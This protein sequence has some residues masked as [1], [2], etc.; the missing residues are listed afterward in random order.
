MSLTPSTMMELGTRAPD[1]ELLDVVTGRLVTRSEFEGCKG[2]LVLFICAHC[3]YVKH[4]NAELAR[5]GADYQPKD[6]GVVAICSNDAINYPDDAPAK[7]NEQAQSFGFD[8][9]Y[10]HDDSQETAKAYR[11]A[12]TPDIFLFDED[13]ELVYRGQLDDSRPGS[14]RPVTGADLRAAIDALLAGEPVDTEQLPATGCN[15][16]W[17]PGSEPDYFG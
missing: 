15:I 1:F 12:C 14:G 11:A 7:L 5:L 2:L 17:K 10:L 16:K 3:P 8:F 4:V 13:H 6:L 9:P